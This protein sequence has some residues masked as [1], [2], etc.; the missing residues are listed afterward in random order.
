MKSSEPQNI[1]LPNLV[2]WCSKLSQNNMRKK[3]CLLSSRSRSQQGLIWSKFDS[4]YCSFWTA[5]LFVTRLIS[6]YIIVSQ[7]RV[8]YEE[9]GLLCL[10]SRSQQEFEMLLNVCPHDIFWI[11]GTFTT[12]LGMVM[13][14]YEPD[15]P[16]KRVACCVQGYSERSHNQNMIFCYVFG[17][18][19]PFATRFDGTAS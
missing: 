11:A 12:K 17:T 8:S 3:N 2:W 16:P 1:L 6:L 5:N 13:H 19:N 10:R 14:Q 7:G 9:I 18:A 15:C 4:F